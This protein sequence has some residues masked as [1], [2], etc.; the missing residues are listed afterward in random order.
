L[1]LGSNPFKKPCKDEL[2][3]RFGQRLDLSK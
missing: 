1:H 3:K 2:Q